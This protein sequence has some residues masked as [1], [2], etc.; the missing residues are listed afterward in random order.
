MFCL[1]HGRFIK[2]L[3]FIYLTL[4]K[5]SSGMCACYSINPVIV[6]ILKRSPFVGK[7][8]YRVKVSLQWN[9]ITTVFYL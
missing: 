7:Q 3:R 6:L 1:D 9:E 5:R 4:N 2:M 8:V